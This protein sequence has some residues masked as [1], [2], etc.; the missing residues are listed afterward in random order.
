MKRT[1]KNIRLSD[2]QFPVDG[3]M[4]TTEQRNELNEIMA[5]PLFRSYLKLRMTVKRLKHVG[6]QIQTSEE[7]HQSHCMPHKFQTSLE[8]RYK[9]SIERWYNKSAVPQIQ[10]R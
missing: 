6:T 3:A 2:T 8:E 9:E 1:Q 10:D 5:S 7:L 4:W